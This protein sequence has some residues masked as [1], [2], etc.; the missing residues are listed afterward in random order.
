M[1]RIFL[2]GAPVVDTGDSVTNRS[3]DVGNAS[4]GAFHA[5]DMKG[6]DSLLMTEKDR[7]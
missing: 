3:Q 7:L 1:T 5:R 4:N 6:L 2:P